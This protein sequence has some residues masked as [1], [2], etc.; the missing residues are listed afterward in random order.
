[1]ITVKNYSHPIFLPDEVALTSCLSLV[2]EDGSL[3]ER[4]L[5]CTNGIEGVE[6][7]LEKSFLVYSITNSVLSLHKEDHLVELIHFFNDEY[8]FFHAQRLQIIQNGQHESAIFFVVP[9]VSAMEIFV[10]LELEDGNVPNQK[11][12]IKIVAIDSIYL[13][14]S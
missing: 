14:F 1:M 8:V 3:P 11:L 7:L 6:F 9:H 5:I 13:F 2:H 12:I 4:H 10:F